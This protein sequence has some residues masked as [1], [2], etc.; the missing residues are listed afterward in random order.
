TSLIKA[1]LFGDSGGDQLVILSSQSQKINIGIF[2][3]LYAMCSY[4][5]V[6]QHNSM[7]IDA[8]MWLPLLTLGIEELIRNKKYRLFVSMLALIMLSNFYI[9]YMCCIFTLIYFFYYYYSRNE[10]NRNNHLGAKNHFRKSFFRIAGALLAIGISMVI[11]A[12]AYYSLQFGKNT[13]SNPDFSFDIRFDLMDFFTKLLPGA[14]DTVR[15]EGLPFIYC[16]IIT[17]YCIPVYF[18]SKKFSVREKVFAGGIL[19]ILFLCFSVNTVDMVWH[20]F[21]K[22]NWLNYRYSFMFSFMMIVLGFKGVG[23]IRKSSGKIIG[24]C[25]AFLVLFLSTAQKFY[26]HAIVER[27]NGKTEFD[28][29]LETLLTVWLSLFFF[30]VVGVTLCIAVKSKKPHAISLIIGIIVC[31][32]AFANGIVCCVEFGND[33]IYSSYSSY[34]DFI[35]ALRPLTTEIVE[36]DKSFF[37]F[38][39][40]AHRKYCDNMALNIRGITNSTSTL[41]KATIEFLARIGYASR[42]HWSK[43]LGGNPVNDSLI[44]MKYIIA[45]DEDRYNAFYSDAGFETV[46]VNSKDYMTYL[47]PYALSLVYGVDDAVADFN[48][49]NNYATPQDRLNAL[50][51]A[52]TGDEALEVFTPLEYET[53]TNNITS[54]T[55]AG[56]YKYTHTSSESAAVLIYTFKTVSEGEVYFYLPSD[57]AREVQMKVNGKSLGNFYGGETTRIFSLGYFPEG[58][59]I[60]LSMTLD[61]DVLYVKQNCNSVFQ[62]NR[63]DFEKAFEILS[64]K[65]V[66]ISDD[67]KSTRLEGTVTTDCDSQ[68]MFTTLPYDEGWHVTVDGKRVDIEKSLDAM[69]SFRIEG[70]G[71]HTVKL[72]YAPTIFILGSAISALSLILFI[73]IMIFEKQI[74][75]FFAQIERQKTEIASYEDELDD[76]YH[77]AAPEGIIDMYNGKAPAEKTNA[78]EEPESADNNTNEENPSGNSGTETPDERND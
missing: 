40:D 5:V 63:A 9:G 39:K 32:E 37:R 31:I 62:L 30:I 34:N 21:Q 6:Q 59:E 7:W 76:Y 69:I 75:A 3:V 72:T 29:P 36:S 26:Y 43:Y 52:M 70:A 58:K 27:I 28:Q 47:N 14:Y 41:N 49:L 66:E 53:Q 65:N 24:A 13:F 1:G 42:S 35:Q 68:L 22:P 64:A 73:L 38:E 20:G 23:E 57:Y 2:S 16:G 51:V 19:F 67:W 25:L 10:E 50:I 45:E 12:T 8:L 61:A 44:G 17:L 77:E 46:T 55:I 48:M 56:H 74:S 15:P 33:V 78:S 18:C 4:A 54:S 71:D 60:T 11:V